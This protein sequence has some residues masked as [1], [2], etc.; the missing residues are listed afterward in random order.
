MYHGT[1]NDG[2]Q[3]DWGMPAI[4][5]HDIDP[6]LVSQPWVS[7]CTAA[8]TKCYTSA[9]YHQQA[10]GQAERTIQNVMLGAKYDHSHWPKLLPHVVN[11][12]NSALRLTTTYS[13]FQLMYGRKPNYF[14][15]PNP[16]SPMD[17]DFG[18]DQQLMR[19]D[20]WDAIQ[21]A[22]ARMKSYYDNRHL[23]P[24]ALDV[25]DFVYVKLAK[26]GQSLATL[27]IIFK[28]KLS[29]PIEKLGRLRLLKK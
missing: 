24:P 22:T 18:T 25:G 8:G 3:S 16:A 20:A 17:V 14:L 4:F 13:P 10:N 5:V 12:V 9:A 21:L 28:I 23:K 19:H 11:C 2:Q 27:A 29:F 7:L 15:D 6:K 1:Q 26:P